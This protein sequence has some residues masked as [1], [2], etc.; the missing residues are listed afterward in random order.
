[1]E[2]IKRIV[3]KLGDLKRLRREINRSIQQVRWGAA[4]VKVLFVH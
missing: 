4:V 3:K 2:I 1:M